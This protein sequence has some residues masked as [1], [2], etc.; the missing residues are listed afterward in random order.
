MTLT[1][2]LII[3][4]VLAAALIILLLVLL[5][6]ANTEDS[7]SNV[8]HYRKDVYVNGGADIV[9]GKIVTNKKFELSDARGVDFR[10]VM[11]GNKQRK[12]PNFVMKRQSDGNLYKIPF[13]GE[14]IVGRGKSAGGVALLRISDDTSVSS[15][16]CR[17]FVSGGNSYVQD[18]GS[19]NRT[20]LNG[21]PLR[22]TERLKNGD[23][24]KI[25]R[26]YYVVGFY[27]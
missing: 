22:H 26:Y 5:K 2:I 18:L 4:G 19:Q 3:M 24:L 6:N 25:G 17:I 9:T 14:L 15:F 27:M 12:R 21:K 1:I 16:H 8:P 20:Y 7:P 11:I 23:I 10:T 13:T